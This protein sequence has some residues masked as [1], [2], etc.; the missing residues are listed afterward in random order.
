MKLARRIIHVSWTHMNSETN[1][2]PY[3]QSARARAAEESTQR[4]LDAFVLRAGSEWFDEIRLDDVASDAGVTVQTVIRKFGG[5]DGL[6]DAARV[7]MEAEI[8][9]ERHTVV[10]D[11]RQ[12]I[13]LVIS[14]YERV[15]DLVMNMLNQ[16]LRYPAIHRVTDLGRQSH[17]AWRGPHQPGQRCAPPHARQ[18]RHRDR[19]LCLEAGAA[20]HGPQHRRP[21]RHHARDERRRHRLRA[22]RADPTDPSDSGDREMTACK[23]PRKFLICTWEG[24][25]SVGPKVTLARKLLAA[26]HSVRVMSDECN[27]PEAEAVGATFVPWTR[28]PNRTDRRRE[29][30]F[31][32]DWA[33]SNPAEGF[34]EATETVFA[35]PALA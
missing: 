14:E 5:K 33:A 31:F 12:A 22:R 32:R 13:A 30:E 19:S 26:G 17:P 4:I 27:R 3:R 10:G 11:V 35:G 18:A 7:R 1:T 28:A 20:R 29:T 25:G 9:R 34:R 16:E 21:F 2:R 23:T 15:G 8:M 6:L 24:G